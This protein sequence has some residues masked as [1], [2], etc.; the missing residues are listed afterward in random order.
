MCFKISE[1]VTSFIQ[2]H[3]V[4]NTFK[5]SIQKNHVEKRKQEKKQE[6]ED[7]NLKKLVTKEKKMKKENISLLLPTSCKGD[8]LS[9]K[10]KEGKEEHGD[11]RL[12]SENDSKMKFKPVDF[13]SDDSE[14]FLG[15]KEHSLKSQRISFQ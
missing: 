14:D 13:C 6:E 5:N 12:G 8:H 10:G 15:D 9:R 3:S 4:E 1:I 7:E 2:R 11:S